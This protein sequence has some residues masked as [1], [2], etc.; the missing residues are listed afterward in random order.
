MTPP[1]DIRRD[2][3]RHLPSVEEVLHA[4]PVAGL[5]AEVERDV[6]A[7]F[8]RERLD[9]WRDEIRS[10]AL[11][12]EGVERRL[13]EGELVRELASRVARESGAGVVGAVNATGVVLHTGLGRAPVHAE[14][15]AA[16]ARAARSYCVLEVDRYT[17][18]RNRR[19]DRV[20]DLLCRLTGAEAGIA[21]NNN[22]AAVLLTLSTF[23][24]GRETIA[25]RGELVEIGGSF[26]MPDVCERAG[27]R[28]VEVGTTNRTRLADYASAITDATGLLFKV[29][30]SNFKVEGF[31]EAVGG[32]EL[33]EL[34][35]ERGIATA[36]DL[37]SGLLELA[38]TPPLDVLAGEP[39][40]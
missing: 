29:H 8:V 39:L 20:S 30:T 15:A 14:A 11:D 25:S 10:G 36:H 28:M 6:L 1:P 32:D 9:A 2:A 37:G 24:G 22:A 12:A 13:A 3:F 16:M 17:G 26:R 33:G 7:G 27:T 4:P 5:L 18:E 31:T 40:V 23:A 19:D 38:G 35:R 34:G 21:V